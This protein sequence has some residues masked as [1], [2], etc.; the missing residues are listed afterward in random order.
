MSVIGCVWGAHRELVKV[1]GD[2]APS[3]EWCE[4]EFTGRLRAK[5]P[6]PAA[7][8]GWLYQELFFA[9]RRV[10]AGERSAHERQLSIFEA[11]S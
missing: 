4:D 7:V 9:W 3:Y 1:L 5:A 11:T 8:P 10:T 6:A 2:D